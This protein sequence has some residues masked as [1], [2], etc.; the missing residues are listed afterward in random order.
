MLIGSRVKQ[1][2]ELRLLTQT[3]LAEKTRLPQSIISRIEIGTHL[4]SPEQARLI[5]DALETPVSFF[6]R[7]PVELPDGSL[8][9]FRSHSSKV[10]KADYS[11]ARRVAEIGVEAI[12]RLSE[13]TAIPPNRLEPLIGVD[14][15][16]ASRFARSMLRLPADEP[17]P[18]LT[19]AM[20]KSG[21]LVLGL[22]GMNA[23][24]QG[25]SSWID[26]SQ[27]GGASDRAMV[28]VR[29]DS[30]PFRLRF[31]LAH[32]L[33]HLVLRHQVFAGPH[34]PV[35]KEANLFAQALLLP[36]DSILEDLSVEPLT[37]SRLAILKGKWGVSMHAI[38]M[39]AKHLEIISQDQYRSIYELLRLRGFLKVEP[40]DRT[41]RAESPKLLTE[42]LLRSYREVSAYC[43]AEKFDFPLD[44]AKRFFDEP[45]FELNSHLVQVP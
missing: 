44:T 6:F 26:R 21:V 12:F 2:R 38:A 43:L 39:R 36:R 42:L 3:G 18:N 15:D 24:I 11:H 29:R 14:L 8:G 27:N 34:Q 32:E 25:F 30:S 9:L 7:K 35:E 1:A 28:V 19:T 40:G 37:L 45:D 22:S 23:A 20:E 16:D 17:I 31:T 33:G 4:A 13:N 5:A 41:T 10:S